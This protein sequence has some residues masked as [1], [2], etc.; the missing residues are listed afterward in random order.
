MSLPSGFFIQCYS[1]E[2]SGCNVRIT[3]YGINKVDLQIN[4]AN[5]SVQRK[6]VMQDF[7]V[8]VAVKSVLHECSSVAASNANQRRYY[9]SLR[10]SSY[11]CNIS[12]IILRECH[13]YSNK[14]ILLHKKTNSYQILCYVNKLLSLIQYQKYL[15]LEQR[16]VLKSCHIIMK[17]KCVKY[18]CVDFPLFLSCWQFFLCVLSLLTLV[19]LKSESTHYSLLNYYFQ[20]QALMIKVRICYS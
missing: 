17:V 6:T 11:L 14:E 16:M 13:Y 5:K 20:S 3:L 1:D 2:L 9:N 19:P 10:K 18:S 4:C 7:Y 8:G 12:S 15:I